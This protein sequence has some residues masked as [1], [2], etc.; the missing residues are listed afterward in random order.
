MSDERTARINTATDAILEQCTTQGGAALD[1]CLN[2]LANDPAWTAKDI[3]IVGAAVQ[4]RLKDL[5]Q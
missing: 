5:E 3:E 4:R 1:R 2:A